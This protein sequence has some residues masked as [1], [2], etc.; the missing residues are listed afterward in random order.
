MRRIAMIVGGLAVFAAIAAG[1]YFS[2]RWAY[3]AYGEYYYV[4]VDLER[5]GQQLMEE[6]DV[7][8]KGAAVLAPLRSSRP[9][10]MACGPP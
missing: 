10:G 7:R 8:V 3:G 5:T 4:T 1:I 9:C 2:V 6:S